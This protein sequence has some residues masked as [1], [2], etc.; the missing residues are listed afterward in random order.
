MPNEATQSVLTLENQSRLTLTGVERVD[1]F[2][3]HTITL[4]VSGKRVRIDG[5]KLKVL[6]FSEGSG[7]FAASGQIDAVRYASQQGAGVKRLFQ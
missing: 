3:E 7:S 4:T 5:S 6:S 1:S 2:S